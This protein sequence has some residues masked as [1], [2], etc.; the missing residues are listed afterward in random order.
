MLRDFGIF[1]ALVCLL[2]SVIVVLNA[3]WIIHC[4]DNSKDLENKMV[5]KIKV[6]STFVSIL[7]LYI[8]AILIK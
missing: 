4:I 3:R 1:I 8:L 6:V 5:G 7:S 2:L